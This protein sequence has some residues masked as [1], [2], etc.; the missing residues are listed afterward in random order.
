ML[1]GLG[2]MVFQLFFYFFFLLFCASKR[3]A[4]P[5][6][7]DTLKRRQ[8]GWSGLARLQ[9]PSEVGEAPLV[10]FQM[11]LATSAQAL[12]T[13]SGGKSANAPSKTAKGQSLVF[14][15]LFLSEILSS[16]LKYSPSIS[17]SQH[18]FLP[19]TCHNLKLS[20]SL[21]FFC[22]LIISFLNWLYISW[23]KGP[24]L[25]HSPCNLALGLMPGTQQ[26]SIRGC[27]ET[28]KFLAYSLPLFPN[29]QG[30]W[31]LVLPALPARSGH[32]WPHQRLCCLGGINT[33]PTARG[34]TW[35]DEAS[36]SFFL[37]QCRAGHMIPFGAI[38]EKRYVI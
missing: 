8:K 21:K 3:R 28:D 14:C 6:R 33:I 10:T 17:V 24:G 18:H 35:R 36:H 29:L 25:C 19:S 13:F 27:R 37:A 9:R 20:R 4:G 15:P 22:L 38:G 5:R 11:G 30:R 12:T 32:C 26:Y 1:A 31:P 2:I 16:F 7:G 23:G 34:R